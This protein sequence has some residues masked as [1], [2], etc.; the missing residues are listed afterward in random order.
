MKYKHLF[1]I[2]ITV[3]TCLSM[4]VAAQNQVGTFSIKPMAGVNISNFGNSTIDIYKSKVGFTAGAELEYGVNPWLG[5]SLGLA[6]SQQGAKIDGIIS[7]FGTDDEGYNFRSSSVMNGKL[8]CNYLNLPIMANIYIPAVKGLALKAGM[9]VGLLTGDK[10][11]TSVT[12]YMIR[13]A[14]T[15]ENMAYLVEEVSSGYSYTVSQTDICKSVDFS[16]PVGLSYEF[17]NIS[18]DARYCF[19]LKKIDKTEDPDNS[20]NRYLS[21]T[22]GY[23]FHL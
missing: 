18:L 5:L 3:L 11:D 20:R 15:G 10:M 8:N 2:L 16:I 13:V 14:P 22:L 1:T 23:R 19:G 12:T 6:Y 9:Q 7:L 17:K 4:G 21:I